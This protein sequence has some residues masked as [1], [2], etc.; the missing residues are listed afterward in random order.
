MQ[1]PQTPGN[2]ATNR[3]R[4]APLMRRPWLP[5]LLGFYALDSHRATTPV[6]STRNTSPRAGLDATKGRARR[7]ACRDVH[8]V[9]HRG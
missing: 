5:E 1:Q 7:F 6:S 3:A 8:P 9:P 4:Q 2:H